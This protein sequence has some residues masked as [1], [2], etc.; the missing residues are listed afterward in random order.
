MVEGFLA[1]VYA[2]ETDH[3]NGRLF[4]DNMSPLKRSFIR[5]KMSR[6]ARSD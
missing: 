6:K 3:L 4:I 5:K 1:R 2:H